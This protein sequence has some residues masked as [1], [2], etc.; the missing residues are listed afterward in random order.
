MDME[1]YHG[2][3]SDKATSIVEN[4]FTMPRKNIKWPGDLGRGVYTF[5]SEV[6][7]YIPGH[8]AAR[9][10]AKKYK[11]SPTCV[12]KVLLSN[13]DENECL[14]L[15]NDEEINL[16]IDARAKI[17]ELVIKRANEL[18]KKDHSKAAKRRNLEGVFMDAYLKITN[19]DNQI[20][21]I[22]KDRWED[23][24]DPNQKS[25]SG[26]IPNCQVILLRHPD[27]LDLNFEILK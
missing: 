25:T 5:T 20:N 7:K 12:L 3:E 21:I 24:D 4:G 2:T 17:Q 6:K 9:I 22:K 16:F 26:Q 18:A 11:S 27:R 23:I 8:E 1:L 13:I 10:Y 14:D 19:K 15:N